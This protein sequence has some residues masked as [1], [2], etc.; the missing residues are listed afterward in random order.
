M[1][2]LTLREQLLLGLL[3]L[4]GLAFGGVY[5]QKQLAG[6]PEHSSSQLQRQG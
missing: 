3:L 6:Q 2:E 1:R 4:I 5:V